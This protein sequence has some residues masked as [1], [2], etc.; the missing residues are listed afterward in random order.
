MRGNICLPIISFQVA[1]DVFFV[2]NEAAVALN[3]VPKIQ[4][5]AKTSCD[6]AGGNLYSGGNGPITMGTVGA[7]R[8]E[9]DRNFS[10]N[11]SGFRLPITDPFAGI[12]FRACAC[13]CLRSTT[14]TRS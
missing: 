9:L 1:S 8:N 3:V 10:A 11:I 6:S 2:G 4:N 5:L 13:H 7:A 14:S 12:I